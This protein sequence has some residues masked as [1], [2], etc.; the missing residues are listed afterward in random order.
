MDLRPG[1]ARTAQFD[2]QA[3]RCRASE[4]G[5]ATFV[6][7]ADGVVDRESF[8]HAIRAT[9]PLDP[10]LTGSRSWDAMSDSLWEGLY[11]LP[12]RQIAILWPNARLMA[13]AASSDFQ[14]ALNVLTDVVNLLANRRATNGSPKDVSVVIEY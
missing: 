10:P 4:A 11:A 6:L 7:P 8:F 14:M 5:Y 12:D 9:L 1:I 2:V 3:V 13:S